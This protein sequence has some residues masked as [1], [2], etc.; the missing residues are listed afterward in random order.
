MKTNN[1]YKAI[2]IAV[3]GM[4]VVGCKLPADFSKQDNLQIPVSYT[5]DKDTSNDARISWRSYFSDPLLIALV[6]TAL[7]HNQ[8]LNMTMQEIEI[9]KNE[10]RARKGEYL[11]FVGLRAGAGYEHLPKNSWRGTVEENVKVDEKPNALTT[12]TDFLIAPVASWEID[13]WKKLRNAKNAAVARY[14]ASIEGRNFM[15]TQLIAEIAESYYELI[16]LDNMLEIIDQNIAIQD[17]ALRVVQMQKDAA[18]LTQLAVNRFSALV[19]NTRNLRYA[20]L[21]QMNQTENRINF[22]TGRFPQQVKRNA[23]LFLTL[24]VD[25]AHAG[26]P[27]QLLLNRPDI[28]QAEQEL[29]AAR[30]DVKSARARFYPSLGISAAVGLNAFNAGYLLQPQSLMYQFSGDIVAPLINRNAIRAAYNTAGARQ[31]QAIYHYEQTILQSY[32]DVLN[33]LVKLENFSKSFDVKNQE[34]QVLFQSVAIAGNLFNA[35]RADYGE[36]LLTQREA[37]EAKM[38]LIEIRLKQLHAHVNIYR[39]LGGGLR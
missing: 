1:M 23:S 9:S 11:P 27:A 39:A 21:Q 32:T 22:L 30:L 13:I 15:V 7:L 2:L 24:T 36:V 14:L 19:L 10:I 20:V 33:Q 8:E 34:V 18:R 17:N 28:R 4:F 25:S 3:L 6:D 12:N 29:T 38:D 37:L 5:A 35:A 26:I 16:A 31:L